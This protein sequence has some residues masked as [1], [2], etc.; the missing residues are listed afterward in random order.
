[1]QRCRLYGSRGH[2]AQPQRRMASQIGGRG[3][4]AGRMGLQ[5]APLLS[6]MGDSP[7]ISTGGSLAAAAAA[8]AVATAAPHR[9]AMLAAAAA[10]A[11]AMDAA[12]CFSVPGAVVVDP[13]PV[14][15]SQQGLAVGG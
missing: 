15:G 13:P 11:L 5:I 4:V 2:S 12:T 3:G 14:G 10:A 6:A 7:G 8:A 1:M 9:E